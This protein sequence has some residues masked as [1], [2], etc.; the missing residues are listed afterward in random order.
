[1]FSSRSVYGAGNDN[2]LI[3]N[4][5]VH[6]MGMYSKQTRISHIMAHERTTKFRNE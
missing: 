6:P 5:F 4:K 3:K 1:M 2:E